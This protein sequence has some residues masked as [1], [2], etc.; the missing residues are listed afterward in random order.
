MNATDTNRTLDYRVG[1]ALLAQRRA[2]VPTP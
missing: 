2:S 1:I